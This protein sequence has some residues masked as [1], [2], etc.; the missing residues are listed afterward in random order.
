MLL[1]GSLL[2]FVLQVGDFDSDGFQD[3][4]ALVKGI[5]GNGEIMLL[6]NTLGDLIPLKEKNQSILQIFDSPTQED[7]AKKESSPFF[8][9]FKL[10]TCRS[11]AID[12]GN[13]ILILQ[14]RRGR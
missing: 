12:S 1:L 2:R 11:Q 9:R 4:L 6:R 14:F 13:L 3:V 10:L 8:V 7:N 5:S